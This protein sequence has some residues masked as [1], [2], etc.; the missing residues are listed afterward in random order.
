[1]FCPKCGRDLGDG[2]SVCPWCDGEPAQPPRKPARKRNGA[3]ASVAI[4][5]MLLIAACAVAVYYGG[6]DDTTSSDSGD[7]GSSG[8]AYTSGEITMEEG[9]YSDYFTIEAESNGDGTSTLTFTLAEDVA[10]N[11]T[12]F[13]WYIYSGSTRIGSTSTSSDTWASWTIDDGTYGEYTVYVSCSNRSSSMGGFP[14][15]MSPGSLGQAQYYFTFSIDGT[16]TK[17]YSWTYGGE[18]YSVS[19]E[20]EYSEYSESLNG[21]AHSGRMYTTSFET[22]RNF[23]SVDDTTAE[24]QSK[25]ASA[26]TTATGDTADGQAYAEY[27]LAFVQICFD[28]LDDSYTYG[29][30]EFY[31]YSIETLYND[32]GDCEDTSILLACLYISAGYDA[33]VFVIPG[34]VIA[35]VYIDGYVAGSTST[36]S[37]IAQFSYTYDGKTYYGCETTL[38]SNSYGIG[39]ISSTYSIGSDGTVYYNGMAYTTADYGLKL[40]KSTASS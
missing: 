8:T 7:G 25:L 23:L 27:L 40:P 24:L 28:Y 12:S 16:V 31:A 39:W 36:T 34:H 1:M 29:Y 37:S 20:F 15:F 32:G 17:T 30:E 18:S 35:A 5:A 2:P 19:I 38:D 13:T 21:T 10:S 3:I 4:V 26:Y 11:Y 6:S 33:G 14:G 9:R 22:I